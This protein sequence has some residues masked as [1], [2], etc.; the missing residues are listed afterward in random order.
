MGRRARAGFAAAVDSG[1]ERETGIEP[2]ILCL[3]GSPSRPCGRCD[4]V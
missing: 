2:A 4:P 1:L 3:Y